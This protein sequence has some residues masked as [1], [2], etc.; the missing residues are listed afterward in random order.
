MLE[1]SWS[2]PNAPMSQVEFEQFGLGVCSYFRL[3]TGADIN[4]LYDK[5][6][7]QQPDDTVAVLMNASGILIAI[8]DKSSGAVEAARGWNLNVT[9]V[10]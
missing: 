2:A 5:I 3:M 8:A 10:Q 6:E 4:R 1:Q 7:A 9:P